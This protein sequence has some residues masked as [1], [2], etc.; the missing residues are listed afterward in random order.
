MDRALVALVLVRDQ[1]VAMVACDFISSS[2]L[3]S[4]AVVSSSD[5][6]SVTLAVVFRL[7]NFPVLLLGLLG[8]L[9]FSFDFFGQSLDRFPCIL[10]PKHRPSLFKRLTSLGD[11]FCP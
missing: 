10:Q 6:T 3:L 2:P 11:S 5:S 1:L 4:L 9:S 8:A 7:W